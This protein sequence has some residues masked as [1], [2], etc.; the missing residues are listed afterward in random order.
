MRIYLTDQIAHDLNSS[1]ENIDESCA[2]I[3]AG[4][5]LDA[6]SRKDTQDLAVCAIFKTAANYNDFI[7]IL[8]LIMKSKFFNVRS[9]VGSQRFTTKRIMLSTF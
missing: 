1:S 3:K 7:T 2:T 6:T 5:F 9:T 4:L 8:N